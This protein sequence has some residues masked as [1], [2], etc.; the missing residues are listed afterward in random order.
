MI[1]CVAGNDTRP[2]VLRRGNPAIFFQVGESFSD[3]FPAYGEYVGQFSFGGE[4]MVPSFSDNHVPD[5]IGNCFRL[6]GGRLPRH[7]GKV[8]FPDVGFQ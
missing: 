4:G 1:R 7:D 3:S 6:D 2:V 5:M 8:L